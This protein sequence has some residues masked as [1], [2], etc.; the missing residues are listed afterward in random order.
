MMEQK[1]DRSVASRNVR[2]TPEF[3]ENPDIAKLARAL[4][5]IA[6]KLSENEPAK[7]GKEAP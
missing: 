7:D 2:V 6:Q 1:R 3:R 4:L 5:A